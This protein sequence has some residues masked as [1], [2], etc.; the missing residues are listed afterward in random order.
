MISIQ[1]FPRRNQSSRINTSISRSRSRNLYILYILFNP[2]ID[3]FNLLAFMPMDIT[4]EESIRDI[5][6]QADTILQVTR[7]E[8]VEV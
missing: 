7:V 5:I 2:K 4:D 6:Y 8:I 1:T 3:E